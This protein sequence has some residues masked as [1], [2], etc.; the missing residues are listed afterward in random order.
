MIQDILASL[1]DLYIVSLYTQLKLMCQIQVV[2]L[3]PPNVSIRLQV[4]GNHERLNET[5]PQIRRGSW[6]LKWEY[7]YLW[8]LLVMVFKIHSRGGAEWHG[9]WQILSHCFHGTRGWTISNARLN[10]ETFPNILK[11]R[12][13]HLQNLM[14]AT[15][16]SYRELREK[17]KTALKW[18][19]ILGN[20]PHKK[21]HTT[22]EHNPPNHILCLQQNN[23]RHKTACLHTAS[24]L[25]E[26][27]PLGITENIHS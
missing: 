4:C 24:S 12:Q 2:F 19:L 11:K 27:L 22:S 23:K 14:D 21:C 18:R 26:F 25:S 7:A 15:S 10:T 13:Q 6:H 17:S 3:P 20:L 8:P 16:V 1:K 9:T 5:S